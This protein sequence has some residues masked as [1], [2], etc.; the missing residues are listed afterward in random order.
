V[1]QA[2]DREFDDLFG[3]LN[4]IAEDGTPLPADAELEYRA[5]KSFDQMRNFQ[6]TDSEIATQYS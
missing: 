5:K 2:Q 3:K 6:P 1:L 4:A